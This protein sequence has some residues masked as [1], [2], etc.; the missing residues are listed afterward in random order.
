MDVDDEQTQALLVVDLVMA[1][2]LGDCWYAERCE[3]SLDGASATSG[4]LKHTIWK[5][6]GRRDLVCS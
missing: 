4:K 3:S 1:G 6:S 5:L 2:V